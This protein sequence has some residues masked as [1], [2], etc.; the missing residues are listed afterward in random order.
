MS[1]LRSKRW[2]MTL[3][4]YPAG[5]VEWM[6]TQYEE[7]YVKYAIIGREVAETGT[8]HL[9]GYLELDRRRRLTALV[10]WTRGTPM[11]G[12]HWERARGNLEQNQEYCK[13]EDQEALELGEPLGGQGARTDLHGLLELAQSGASHMAMAEAN[14]KVHARFYLWADMLAQDY[15]Q[16]DACQALKERFEDVVLRPWQRLA[17]E[18]LEAQGERNILWIWETVGKVG[19]SWLAKYIFSRDPEATFMFKGGKDADAA[20][21]Y[22]K[23]GCPPMVIIDLSRSNRD[24]CPYGIMEDW[25]DGT[26]FTGKYQARQLVFAPAKVVVLANF[27]PDPE[28]VSAD[29][30]DMMHVVMV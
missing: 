22:G 6:T 25:K 18:R 11:T 26:M 1:R 30:W 21:A 16:A 29:R 24:T 19:K 4:N 27:E 17:M 9:Q 13:K 5:W 20:Y 3:N 28:R 23:A 7:G 14:P 15:R 12:A 2:C 8:P 10:T